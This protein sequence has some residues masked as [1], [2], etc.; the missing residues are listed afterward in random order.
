MR[1][2]CHGQ[3]SHPRRRLLVHMAMATLLSAVAA[4]P[5]RAQC[6]PQEID[7]LASDGEP[8][9]LFGSTIAIDA[10][11]VIVG[12]SQDDDVEGSAYVFE[13]TDG[14]WMEIQKLT[15]PDGADGDWFSYSVAIDADTAVVG[16]IRNDEN[17][18]DAGAAY[19]YQRDG[20]AWA[21]S[22]KLM[23]SDGAAGDNFGSGVGVDGDTM[24][25]GAFHHVE[26]GAAY[27]FERVGDAWVEIDKLIASDAGA[28]DNFGSAVAIC[29]GTIV[30][31]ARDEDELGTNAGAAYVFELS[32][33]AWIETAK[34]LA[35]DGAVG[36]FF[37]GAAGVDGDTIVVG[38]IFN[39]EPVTDAGA[40]YVFERDGDGVWTES[41]KLTAS[42]P[43]TNDHFG[44]SVAASAETVMVGAFFDGNSGAAYLFDK[45]GDE[46]PEASRLTA[47]DGGGLFGASVGVDGDDAV[48][49]APGGEAAYVFD[50][51][52]A[53][54]ADVN[55]DGNLN[56]LD[57]VAFQL[58]WQDGDPIADCD[59]N[60]EFNVLDFVCFQQLFVEGCP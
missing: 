10:G 41:A 42:D 26:S 3:P 54:P 18:E 1:A 20:G 33:G 57:F 35:S 17:G 12:A 30:V 36:D 19:V 21:L 53:C 52:C 25:V 29:G 55:G 9:D 13:R 43:E 45:A 60:A 23:A 48:V 49:G 56:V 4:T 16:S 24:V 47:S 31:G 5:C 51:N 6:E 38:A 7:K 44:I 2:L 39:D 22:A 50:L 34:L 28:S 58:L 59:A 46:W 11:R 15:P 14:R 27:V 40:A 32:N 37:G 8:G